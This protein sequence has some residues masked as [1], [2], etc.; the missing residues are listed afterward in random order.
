MVS[1]NGLEDR[2]HS[3]P[4][5]LQTLYFLLELAYDVPI[6]SIRENH[7]FSQKKAAGKNCP[8]QAQK[9]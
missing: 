4:R 9:T 3:I 1:H 2:S 6:N 8:A 5:D 7:G